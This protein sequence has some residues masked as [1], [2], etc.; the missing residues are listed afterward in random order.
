[1]VN[2][3]E[4]HVNFQDI[5]HQLR[6]NTLHHFLDYI[7]WQLLLQTKH[8]YSTKSPF[9]FASSRRQSQYLYLIPHVSHFLSSCTNLYL[10]L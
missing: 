4:T 1:M 2:N 5:E 10:T 6:E 9:K 7:V 8:L 3:Y